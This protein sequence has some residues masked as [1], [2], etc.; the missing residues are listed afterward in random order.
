MLGTLLGVV[1]EGGWGLSLRLGQVGEWHAVKGGAGR[2][3]VLPALSRGALLKQLWCERAES[4]CRNARGRIGPRTQASPGSYEATLSS[5][6]QVKIQWGAGGAPQSDATLQEL[7]QVWAGVGVG[8]Q[9]WRGVGSLQSDATL[10]ELL[11][12]WGSAGVGRQVGG[13]LVGQPGAGPWALTHGLPGS[14]GPFAKP[15]RL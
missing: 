5:G 9:V 11:P 2:G 13:K 6:L 7:C 14:V 3:G 15:I 1:G 10:Q 8:Y 4:T 12:V